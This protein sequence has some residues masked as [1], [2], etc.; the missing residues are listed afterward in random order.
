MASEGPFQSERIERA[1]HALADQLQGEDDALA[2][3]VRGS[4]VTRLMTPTSDVDCYVITRSRGPESHHF[5]R[6]GIDFHVRWFPE[7]Y[8]R[9]ELGEFN[10]RYIGFFRDSRSVS[11]P[12]GVYSGLVGESA[13]ID[14]RELA[15]WWMREVRHQLSDAQGQL[16]L[17]HSETA[18]YLTRFAGHMLAQTCLLLTARATYKH[19]DVVSLL[20]E[21][22]ELAGLRQGCLRLM[23]LL[24]VDMA[25]VDESVALLGDLCEQ[26]DC[27]V[28]AGGRSA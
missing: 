7:Q 21:A 12:S 24:P 15:E 3:V 5:E 25:N 17:G 22:E 23:D 18:K 9:Y 1:L 26:A 8:L 20:V 16:A 4:Y 10:L 28:A 27:F 14:Q 6:D 11:D 2:V 19:K 13:N